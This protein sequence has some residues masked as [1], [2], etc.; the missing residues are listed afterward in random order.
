MAVN[1]YKPK[2]V[3]FEGDDILYRKA[4]EY[5]EGVIL[6]NQSEHGIARMLL[7]GGK[8]PMPIYKIL[9]NNGAIDWNNLELFC[10]DERCVPATDPNSNQGNIIKSLSNMVIDNCREVNFFDTSCEIEECV[11][12]YIDK[13]EA[14]DDVWFDIAVLGLGADGNIASLFPNNEYLRHHDNSVIATIAPKTESISQR[15]SLTVESILNSREIL[16]VLNG[17]N[18]INVLSELLE[19]HQKATEFPAKFLLSHPKVSI[20]CC[21]Q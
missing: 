1:I 13:L 6:D 9:G 20:F 12:S 15:V 4:S 17:D 10:S 14:L 3:E 16:I 11:K 8:T 18:K 19:G 7:S 2:V 21:F 5:I